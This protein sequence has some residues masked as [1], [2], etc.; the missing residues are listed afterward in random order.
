MRCLDLARAAILARVAGPGEDVIPLLGLWIQAG[1]LWVQPQPVMCLRENRNLRCC[2]EFGLGC[3]HKFRLPLLIGCCCLESEKMLH[4]F[5]P[6][7]FAV[8]RFEPVK[9]GVHLRIQP[10]F[11]AAFHEVSAL[12]RIFH[13]AAGF[14]FIRPV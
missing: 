3:F 7:A 1:F 12:F 10:E 8:V 5:A 14:H 4:G 13:Q 6:E 11:G 9:R 2:R